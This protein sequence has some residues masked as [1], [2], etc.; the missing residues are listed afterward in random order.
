MLQCDGPS[1]S[2]FEKH[3]TSKIYHKCECGSTLECKARAIGQTRRCPACKQVFVVPLPPE[4]FW[5]SPTGLS[6][7]EYL[8]KEAALKDAISAI[9][10]AGAWDAEM[11]R[12][13]HDALFVLSHRLRSVDH[14]KP[15]SGEQVNPS[16]I[17][18]EPKFHLGVWL[19]VPRLGSARVPP[20]MLDLES[21]LLCDAST[22]SNLFFE[23]LRLHTP[24]PFGSTC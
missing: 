21:G 20:N 1:R 18:L 2:T 5:L 12:T 4:E 11:K 15:V 14:H 24:S 10:K 8:A 6:H 22:S 17:P 23:T 9:R 7:A 3:M 13:V 19:R 16:V